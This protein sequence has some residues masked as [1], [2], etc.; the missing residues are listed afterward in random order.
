MVAQQGWLK[1]GPHKFNNLGK[2]AVEDYIR[3]IVSGVL[4]SFISCIRSFRFLN[5]ILVCSTGGQGKKLDQKIFFYLKLPFLSL[6]PGNAQLILNGEGG[7]ISTADL[8]VLI[9]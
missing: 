6:Y 1:Q 7:S 8:L 4:Y 5:K 9:G 2:W 3:Q